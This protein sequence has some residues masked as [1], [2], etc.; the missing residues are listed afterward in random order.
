L[1]EAVCGENENAFAIELCGH[2]V[3]PVVV[4]CQEATA[5]RARGCVNFRV[6]P[7]TTQV[8]RADEAIL[9]CGRND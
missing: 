8:F 1:L 9:R 6:R 4:G 5:G 3:S 7:K 2:G